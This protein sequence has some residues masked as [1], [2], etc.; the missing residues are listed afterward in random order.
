MCRSGVTFAWRA[1]LCESGPIL[2]LRAHFVPSNLR[3]YGFSKEFSAILIT[4]WETFRGEVGDVSR[5]AM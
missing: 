5:Q 2:L 1:G 4:C 3:Q